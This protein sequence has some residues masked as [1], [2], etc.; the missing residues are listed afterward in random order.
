MRLQGRVKPPSRASGGIFCAGVHFASTLYDPQVALALWV[1]GHRLLP[2]ES[3]RRLAFQQVQEAVSA[4]ARS[5]IGLGLAFYIGGLP[6]AFNGWE[7]TLE[8]VRK[9][10]RSDGT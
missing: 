3:R 4:Q 9:A 10:Q 5:A 7:A 2:E 6:S 8:A 1:L